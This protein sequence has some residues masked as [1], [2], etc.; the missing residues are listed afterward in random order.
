MFACTRRPR[1]P[2]GCALRIGA[3][4]MPNGRGP[5]GETRSY[6]RR[7]HS[8]LGASSYDPIRIRLGLR[9]LCLPVF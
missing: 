6:A 9:G 5:G 1:R 3:I 4:M 2:W 7:L 8:R